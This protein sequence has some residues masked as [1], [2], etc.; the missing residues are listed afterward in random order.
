[1]RNSFPSNELL[2][3]HPDRDGICMG[4][5]MN[6]S[7]PTEW[8]S[9]EKMPIGMAQE[10]N[11]ART[12]QCLKSAFRQA[13]PEG[14]RKNSVSFN[15]VV[16]CRAIPHHREL[17]KVRKSLV[18]ET[19]RSLHEIQRAAQNIVKILN[20]GFKMYEEC[21]E[22]GLYPMVHAESWKRTTRQEE[23]YGY[24]ECLPGFVQQ[25]G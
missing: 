21:G 4:D 12:E 25:R 13:R 3:Q 9:S 6:S 20:Y 11:E 10:I 18:W 5:S 22:R 14:S 23:I 19:S 16:C 15:L 1:M 24:V 2:L 7:F 17:S 8:N